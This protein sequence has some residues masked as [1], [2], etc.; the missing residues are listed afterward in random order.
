MGRNWAITIGINHYDNLQDLICAKRDAEAMR[1]FFRE[2]LGF[3]QIY[4][5]TEDSPPI[6]QQY[7]PQIV[8]RPTYTTLMRFL[9]VRFE[10]P[11][12]R[13]GD[14][15]WFFFAGHGLSQEE[16][17]YLMPLDADPGDVER[18]AIAIGY[19]TERLRRCGADN[20][21]LLIDACRSLSR[22]GTGIGGETQKGV[23]TLFS[24]SPRER[25][26]EIEE[27]PIQHGAF[28]YALLQ[29][30]RLQGEGNCATVERLYQY[31]RYQVPELG[32]RYQKPLQT[33]YAIVE[34]ASKYHLILLPRC[35]TVRDAETLKLEAFRAEQA[36]DFD[37]AEQLWIRVLVVSPG[38]PDALEGIRRVDRLRSAPRPESSPPPETPSR[39]RAQQRVPT[40]TPRPTPEPVSPLPRRTATGPGAAP[41]QLSRR[42]LIQ[43]IGLGGAGAGGAFLLARLLQTPTLSP[44]VTTSP[45]PTSTLT[46]TSSPSPTQA[47]AGAALRLEPVEFAVVTVN[48]Q[49]QKV[50]QEKLK[51]GLYQ[52]DLGGGVRLDMVGIPKGSFT[53]GSPEGEEGRDWY[54]NFDAK[55]TNVEGP[56]HQ[57]AVKAF[58]MGKYQVTQAQW[59]AVAELPKIK[60]DLQ[61]DPSNFKGDNRPVE[62]VSWEEAIEF[63]ARLS[64]KTGREYRLP[65]EAEWEYAC[66]A[67]TTTPFHFGETI[68]TDLAN[69]RGTD[70]E[71]QG[72]TY[73]GNYGQGPHG[74]YRQQ[75][76]EVGSFKVANAFGLYDMHGNVWEW[77]LD[78]WH[79]N[80]NGAP[81][82]GSAWV[83]GGNASRR[84]LRGGSWSLNPGDCRSAHRNRLEPGIRVNYLGFRVV[85]SSAWTL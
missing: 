15:L 50:K 57:V 48:A 67:G 46:P 23:V 84:V 38:D 25:S 42:R 10:E 28:T 82:D 70:W 45:K 33:P 75:T 11:F 59:R 80:Y 49:G 24:C 13:A 1:D 66:R 78:Y 14:N 40:V 29:G 12:L 6:Q 68:T 37:L 30:L 27:P 21:V 31:L 39:S 51:A 16:R 36:G 47:Q 4:H 44:V 54:Q 56:Q 72:K 17:D 22:A 81:A 35:A 9:R 73:P 63:C 60:A 55:L 26:Y 34:P 20:V 53:M 64:K 61:S 76:T 74:S 43:L 32:R 18:T 79:E 71:Y 41:S 52:E 5:F 65:S 19:V 2:E 85:C 8:S 77:C 62:R 7:G 83:T 3:E 58:G 69:Y